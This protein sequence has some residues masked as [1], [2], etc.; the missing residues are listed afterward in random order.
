[1]ANDATEAEENELSKH[2]RRV[3]VEFSPEAQFF[4]RPVETQSPNVSIVF[5]YE[6]VIASEPDGGLD[7]QT[8]PTQGSET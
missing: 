3:R 5:V 1:M 6:N 8:P 2:T 4:A 7:E